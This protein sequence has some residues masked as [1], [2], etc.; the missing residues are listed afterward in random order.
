MATTLFYFF[1]FSISN[2]AFASQLPNI[3]YILFDDVGITD[4]FNNNTESVIPTPFLNS[5]LK[6]GIKF[7]NVNN[8]K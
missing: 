1:V 5:L 3:V 7:T 4:M 8:Y 6:D 2:Y